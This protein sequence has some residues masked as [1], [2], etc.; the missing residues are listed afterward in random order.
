MVLYNR[1]FEA[2]NITLKPVSFFIHD[3]LAVLGIIKPKMSAAQ[4]QLFQKISVGF[5]IFCWLAWLAGASITQL[6]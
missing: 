6:Q 1:R 3:I 4:S 2:K 5:V